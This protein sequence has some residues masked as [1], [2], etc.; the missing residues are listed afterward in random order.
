MGRCSIDLSKLEHELT[1]ELWVDL[2]EG[3]G[4][5]FLLLTI[6]GRTNFGPPIADLDK[7]QLEDDDVAERRERSFHL[8]NT[9]KD[10]NAVGHL[11]VRIYSAKGLYAADLGGKSDPF[12]VLE[13]ENARL[14]TRTEY[15]T[16]APTWNQ[17]LSLPVGDIHSVLHMSVYDEDKNHKYEFLGKTIFPLL[18]TESGRK[19]WIALRDKKLRVRAKGNNPQILVRL[20]IQWN[21]VRAAIR[22]FNP[23][24]EKYMAAVEKFK[25]DVFLKNV[26]RIKTIIMEFV[27]VVKFIES[28]LEWESPW[29]TILAFVIWTVG[30]IFAEPFWAPIILLVIFFRSYLRGNSRVLSERDE[31]NSDTASLDLEHAAEDADKGD[32]A[33]SEEKMT[34]RGAYKHFQ[35]VTAMVQNAL[36]IVANLAEA[37]KN[38]FNFSVPFLSWLAVAA[39]VIAAFFLYFVNLR[40]LLIIFGINKFSKKLIRPN[41]VPNNELL[42]FLSRVPDDEELLDYRD[43]KL[44][45]QEPSH[46]PTRSA[47]RGSSASS[48]AAD[49]KKKKNS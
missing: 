13:L 16:V 36:G 24:E 5:L 47:E 49:R 28:L 46:S 40:Y 42:D 31:D 23:R 33:E 44:L 10:L 22:T 12:V 45:D 9:F 17:V 14:Q 35:D 27:D 8:R 1:H 43:M 6:S 48:S 29:R 18:R 39:L 41:F 15:K 2:E 25:K 19:R 7:F 3:T 26:M 37:V 20:D 34:L 11:Q 4:K 38:T 32:E 30:C 21:T